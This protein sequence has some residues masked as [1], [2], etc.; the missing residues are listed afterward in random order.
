LNAKIKVA[1]LAL[2]IVLATVAAGAAY[3]AYT[4]QSNHVTGPI[5]AQAQFTVTVN[6]SQNNGTSYVEGSILSITATTTDGS[7]PTG[8]VSFLNGTQIIGVATP[9]GN[10]ASF[11]WTIPVGCTAYD[12]HVSGSHS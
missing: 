4:M 8:Q 6:G 1:A 5:T 7:T 9:I 2:A 10:T 3:A 11:Q 12:L